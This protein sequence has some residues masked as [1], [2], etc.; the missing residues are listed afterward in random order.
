MVE[1][2]GP[3]DGVRND[4]RFQQICDRAEIFLHDPRAR[5]YE[6]SS[7]PLH[8]AV[9]ELYPQS[10][11]ELQD[12][13]REVLSHEFLNILRH[14]VRLFQLRRDKNG[15]A[16][17]VTYYNVTFPDELQSDRAAMMEFAAVSLLR[18][19]SRTPV[20]I[21]ELVLQHK[22]T[23]SERHHPGWTNTWKPI[24]LLFDIGLFTI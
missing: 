2:H 17:V 13:I 11:H 23:W 7:W 1:R 12:L 10:L 14:D 22:I 9:P 4:C 3:C 20:N 18:V 19:G 15:E 24:L 16:G 21:F 8:N 6:Q 5:R